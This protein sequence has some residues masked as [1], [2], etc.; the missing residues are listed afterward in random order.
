M[1]SLALIA[2][3]RFL[4]KRA[5]VAMEICIHWKT[6]KHAWISLFNLKYNSIS[7]Y[8]KSSF[9]RCTLVGHVQLEYTFTDTQISLDSVQNC[10]E[11]C[12]FFYIFSFIILFRLRLENKVIT[13]MPLSKVIKNFR[14]VPILVK[15][16]RLFLYTL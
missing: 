15:F 12:A 4:S 10:N 13:M 14:S 1:P 9:D 6:V 5:L 3:F 7:L 16:I 11:M 8:N 2:G